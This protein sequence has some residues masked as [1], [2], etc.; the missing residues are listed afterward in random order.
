MK[1]S[2]PSKEAPCSKTGAALRPG[3][4]LDLV[5]HFDIGEN[6]SDAERLSAF[7]D[8][9]VCGESSSDRIDAAQKALKAATNGS[10]GLASMVLARET[11]N[12]EAAL[13]HGQKAMEALRQELLAQVESEDEDESKVK[14]DSK[15]ANEQYEISPELYTF[16]VADLAQLKWNAGLRKEAV[17]LLTA[18][19]SAPLNEI[20]SMEQEILRDLAT[21]FLIQMGDYNSAQNILQANS[22]NEA[23]W[24]YL[25]AL[26]HFALTGDTLLSRSAL[27]HGFAS[28]S[29][30]IANRLV[31]SENDSF[32]DLLTAFGLERYIED[33]EQAWHSTAGAIEWLA[34]VGAEPDNF[35]NREFQAIATA[36]GDIK[37]W[38]RWED[39][40]ESAHHFSE[41]GNHKEARTAL[42]AALKEAE[43]IEYSFLP[44]HAS[45][46]ELLD[47][48][49]ETKRP[50][51]DLMDTIEARAAKF[52]SAPNSPTNALHLHSLG[53]LFEFFHEFEKAADYHKKA[54]QSAEE[55][56]EG[57]QTFLTLF[58]LVDMR[59]DLAFVLFKL[60][61]H[62]EALP[63]FLKNAETQE[64]FLGPTH[65]EILESLELAYE[66]YIALEE[67]ANADAVLA[68]IKAIDS[69]YELDHHDDDESCDSCDHDHH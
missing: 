63:L 45:I 39:L 37:R 47:L 64:R 17:E 26:V 29:L 2:T 33:T 19:F 12:L 65:G 31:A 38:Q 16:A 55:H 7:L 62:S 34:K 43:R 11:E 24:H 58:D 42:K 28:G 21:S 41:Q 27:T 23:Q 9:A 8:E 69:E 3:V 56:V 15:D 13:E 25:N 52:E 20:D 53:S 6:R 60:K 32:K 44:F 10:C 68:R 1:N 4:H 66:C 5:E 35:S 49:I 40:L 30:L 51:D 36:N 22:N 14:S 57:G 61:H 18:H 54:L 67:Q 48:Y 50:A 46:S 59:N